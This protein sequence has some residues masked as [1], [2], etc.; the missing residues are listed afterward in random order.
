MLEGQPNQTLDKLF[1]ASC[2]ADQIKLGQ[3]G[4]ERTQG[5]CDMKPQYVCMCY[6]MYGQFNMKSCV[7]H[8]TMISMQVCGS[9]EP[10]G[11]D[12]LLNEQ[13]GI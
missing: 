12:Y 10:L 7:N 4:T 2:S 3:A 1:V 9:T 11:A 5:P 13:Y 6:G 8:F